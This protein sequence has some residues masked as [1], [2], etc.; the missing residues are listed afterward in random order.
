MRSVGLVID[1]SSSGA[2][3]IIVGSVGI[4]V[5]VLDG[6]GKLSSEIYYSIRMIS[7][8]NE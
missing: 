3:V 7:R 8:M 4:L 1:M 5:G 6:R 2:L